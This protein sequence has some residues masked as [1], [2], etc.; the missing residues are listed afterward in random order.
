MGRPHRIRLD[1]R[2]RCIVAIPPLGPSSRAP[3]CR[4]ALRLVNVDPITA[5]AEL[6]AAQTDPASVFTSNADM[7]TLAWPGDG[8][9]HHGDRRF[10]DP[11][12]PVFMQPVV[13]PVVDSSLSGP[14]GYAG[15]PNGLKASTAGRYLHTASRPGADV[16]PRAITFG[17]IGSALNKRSPSYF[18]T[19]AELCFIEAAAQ[20]GIGGLTPPQ[21]AG[22]YTAGITASM[23]QWG[24]TDGAAIAAYIAQPSV[25]YTGGTAGLTQIAI[26]KWVAL[27][28]DGSQA[29]QNGAVLASHQRL[30]LDLMPSWTLCHAGS[31]IRPP[32]TR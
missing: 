13:Q 25:A 20:H 26:Q 31:T 27:I 4:L 2:I 7:T 5:D 24:I 32:S 12:T 14:V 23:N 30:R 17:T 22:F 1:P 16:Y 3:A 8:I 18:M 11:R 9:Y 19:Y 15:M 28:D 6:K 10:L 29:W 21:A